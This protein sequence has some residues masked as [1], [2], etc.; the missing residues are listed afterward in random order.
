[1]EPSPP[2]KQAAV[3]LAVGFALLPHTGVVVLTPARIP[4]LLK[5]D[6]GSPAN[7]QRGGVREG[8]KEKKS[9]IHLQKPR[10]KC[11]FVLGSVSERNSL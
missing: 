11:F 5:A 8:G 10:Q 3:P 7:I 1:M 6:A 2:V 9:Q 4:S